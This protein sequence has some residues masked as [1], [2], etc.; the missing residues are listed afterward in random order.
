M[1]MIEGLAKLGYGARGVV[2]GLVGGLA[3]FT[4]I[5]GHREVDS[6]SALDFALEQPLGRLWLGLIA[7][8]LA[9]FVLWRVVQSLAN[10]DRQPEEAKGYLIRG[11][12]L[13]SAITY[14]SLALYAGR[15]AVAMPSGSGSGG[16]RGLAG[17]LIGQPLGRV[18]AGLVGVAILGAGVAQIAKAV[19]KGYRKY[20]SFPPDK[21]GLLDPVC[22]YG[23]GARGLV[24]LITGAFFLYAA[25][26]VDPD[27]AGSLA[28]AMIWIR[29]LPF[30]GILYAAVALGLFFFGA[31][32]VI[33]S[34]YRHIG[35][36]AMPDMAAAGVAA[37]RTIRRHV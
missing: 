33:A 15:H 7:I 24:F 25:W 21:A 28:D 8:G 31:Y 26:M 17:W 36:V 11:G 16:E 30:G 20:M 37:Q 27:Q 14:A 18:L 23:L 1:Q 29:Q 32:S 13:V 6:K 12:L 3:L 2:Y 22:A 19:S 5:G 9:C 34:R 10:A 35:R 4:S